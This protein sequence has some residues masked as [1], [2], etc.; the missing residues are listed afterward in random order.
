MEG[1]SL[2]AGFAAQLAHLLPLY[3]NW[4]LVMTF[5]WSTSM[6]SAVATALVGHSHA[7]H[8]CHTLLY[9]AL[10]E[11]LYKD[12]VLTIVAHTLL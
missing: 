8:F 12:F 4:Q 6:V 10:D 1:I 9:L 11:E 2:T 5:P 7:C 3:L